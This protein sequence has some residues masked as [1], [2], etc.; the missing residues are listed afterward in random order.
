MFTAERL[1]KL[2]SLGPGEG[3]M[4]CLTENHSPVASGGLGWVVL[5]KISYT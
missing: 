5:S 4:K 2:L 1:N 3:F